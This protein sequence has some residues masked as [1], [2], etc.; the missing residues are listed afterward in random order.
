MRCR[1]Q[2]AGSTQGRRAVLSPRRITSKGAG[3][4]VTRGARGPFHGVIRYVAS[5]PNLRESSPYP[6]LTL[7]SSSQRPFTFPHGLSIEISKPCAWPEPALGRA[8][9]PS[10]RHGVPLRG[11]RSKDGV[12]SPGAIRE[13]APTR[14]ASPPNPPRTHS[15][16][17]RR[18]LKRTPSLGRTKH[19]LCFLLEPPQRLANASGHF[20]H[21]APTHA[22]WRRHWTTIRVLGMHHCKIGTIH[23]VTK[24]T[25]NE[26]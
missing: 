2:S 10:A 1:E 3:G 21:F 8:R 15:G 6:Q 16:T 13:A 11:N 19:D 9:F 26:Q 25:P 18:C 23:H 22:R 24:S 12:L 14:R 5:R 17:T 20:V 4:H 7:C